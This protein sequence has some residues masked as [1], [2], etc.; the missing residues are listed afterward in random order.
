MHNQGFSDQKAS[1]DEDFVVCIPTST[2]ATYA[3]CLRGFISTEQVRGGV[4]NLQ[5]EHKRTY[6]HFSA[7][8]LAGLAMPIDPGKEG[9][10]QALYSEA[11]SR[12]RSPVASYRN[13]SP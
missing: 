13:Q 12:S 11:E 3:A 9:L 8:G 4:A 7:I 5:R 6:S 10:V 1:P 2:L